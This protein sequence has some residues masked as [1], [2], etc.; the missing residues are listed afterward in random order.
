MPFTTATAAT[1]ATVAS[2]AVSV[3]GSIQAGRAAQAQAQ[4]QASIFSQQAESARRRAALQEQ[5]FR[6][7][8]TRF[9]GRQRAL[10][11]KA[12]VR[13]EEGTPVELQV[14]TAAEGEFEALLIRAG[15]SIESARLRQ[16]AL[17]ERGRGAGA[18]RASLFTAGET[19]LT[20]TSVLAEQLGE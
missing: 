3:L 16:R 19:L 1:I 6:R 15:G 9:G 17:I 7:D 20:G 14:E 13:L 4:L 18:R 11:A 8:L 12:G 10:L 5:L 2:T